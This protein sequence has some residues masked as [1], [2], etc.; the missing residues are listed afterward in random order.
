M[1]DAKRVKRCGR[2]TK[3]TKE[4]QNVITK[5]LHGGNYLETAAACAG[6]SPHTVR[7]WMARGARQKSGIYAEFHAAIKEAEAIAE[8]TAITRIRGAAAKAWQAEAWY[9]ERKFPAKW[10]RWQREDDSGTSQVVISLTAKNM[11]DDGASD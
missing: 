3:L 8:A 5:W 2:P 10:G 11:G 7:Q 1:S 9:L 4:T 6:V